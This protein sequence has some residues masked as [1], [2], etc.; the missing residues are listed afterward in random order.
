[1]FIQLS[2]SPLEVAGT[3]L[4]LVCI[5]DLT[6]QKQTEDALRK[7]LEELKEANRELQELD[8]IK[9]EFISTASHELRA[10]LAIIREF[11]S[12]VRDG[13][14][15]PISSKQEECLDSALSNCDRLGKI[16]NDLLDLQRIEAGRIKMER[17]RQ[18]PAALL[19]CCT[20][21]FLPRCRSKK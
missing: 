4:V 9:S 19:E 16:V 14:S 5:Q 11:L 10:P 21:D 18:G 15:G 8:S 3:C 1:M 12:L 6:R 20:N 2:A 17:Q 7:A 13:I